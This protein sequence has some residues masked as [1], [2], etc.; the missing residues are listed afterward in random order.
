MAF[1]DYQWV[2]GHNDAGNMVNVETDVPTY[3]GNPFMVQGL[4][5]FSEGLLK[6]SADIARYITGLKQFVWTIDVL[7][8]AQYEDIQSTKTVGGD[9][10]SGDLT[11][12]HRINSTTYANYNA[13]LFLPQQP[14][15][16]LIAKGRGAYSNVQLIFANVE[17]L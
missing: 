6:T 14:E 11:V 10:Y 3:Q 5:S 15:L 12:R 9:S 2:F 17:A 8:I 7:S 4:G 13:T 1:Q 16:N